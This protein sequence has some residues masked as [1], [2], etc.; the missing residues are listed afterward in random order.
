MNTLPTDLS[1]LII[2]VLDAAEC[3]FFG[4]DINMISFEDALRNKDFKLV[5]Y[6][7]R[8]KK[9]R[10]L[11]F[12]YKHTNQNKSTEIMKLIDLIGERMT[13]IR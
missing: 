8:F 6:Y 2:N 5:L 7:I 10:F 4:I 12:I 3:S 1:T 13:D 11:S 9:Y